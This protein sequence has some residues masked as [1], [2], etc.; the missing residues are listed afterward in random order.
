MAQ[1]LNHVQP[2]DI[3]TA[4]MWNLA[5][6]AVNE[7]LQAGQTT[8]IQIA[9]LLP[10]GTVGEPIRLGTLLQ[11][12]GQNFGYSIGQ[13][14]VTF[15]GPAG[16]AVVSRDSMLTGS[17]DSRLLLI[18]P[19]IPALPQ[20][21]ASMALEVNNGVAKDVRTVFVTPVVVT[22]QGDV[23]VNWRANVATNPI[24]NPLQA[25]QAADFLY[26]VQTGINMPAAFDL[27]VTIPNATTAIPPNLVPSIE[28]RQ[29]SGL[30]AG[31]RV[32]MGKSETRNIVVRIPQ[33]P[34][35][36]ASQSFTLQVGASSGTISGSDTR[37]F[38]VGQPVTPTDPNIEVQQTGSVVLNTATG[39]IDTNPVN[40]RLEGSTIRLRAGRQ[41]IVQFNA[42]FLQQGTYGLTIQPRTGST[43]TGWTLQLIN[44]PASIAVT[45]DND[46]SLHL[47]QFGATAAAGASPSGALVFRIQRQGATTDWFKEYEV[48][49]LP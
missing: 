3:I 6:D 46:P 41:M 49:L 27:S 38:T 25:G 26:E 39:D 21:G 47:V 40:G 37:S 12:T 31:N 18:V 48:E 35:S 11:I 44:T 32:D 24:P 43:L 15:R 1:L 30:I 7:L 33:I 42:R 36:F 5:V 16:D 17:S 34:T 45:I 4:E 22:L 23:F 29:D 8:G 19:P 9:A 2:G 14:S 10:A 20:A 13:A 28:L